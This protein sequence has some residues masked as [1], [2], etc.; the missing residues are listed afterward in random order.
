MAMG[1][2]LDSTVHLGKGYALSFKTNTRMIWDTAGRVCRKL[3]KFILP[4]R[5]LI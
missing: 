3:A 4:L 1:Q 2:R 5:T